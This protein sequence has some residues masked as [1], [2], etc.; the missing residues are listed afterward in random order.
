MV[1]VSLLLASVGGE[2]QGAHEADR[3]GIE[4]LPELLTARVV[5]LRGVGDFVTHDTSEFVLAIDKGQEAARDVD[6]A[7]RKCEC[8]RCGLIDDVEGIVEGALGRIG[9]HAPGNR[10]DVL[11]EF[12]IFDQAQFFGDDSRRLRSHLG[13]VEI[14][15][16]GDIFEAL[17]GAWN[18]RRG[19]ADQQ[20]HHPL[21]RP[22]ARAETTTRRAGAG[23]ECNP[24][25]CCDH[26]FPRSRLCQSRADA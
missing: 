10:F 15:L 1:G 6:V 25:Y 19:A 12:G 18:T 16:Q 24:S 5:A 2:L 9:E 14:R 26:L 23:R 8:I 13:I 11:L 20:D 7:A 3:K 22:E 4:P 17:I 21:E